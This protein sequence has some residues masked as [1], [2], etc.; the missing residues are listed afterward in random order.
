M[1]ALE[2]EHADLLSGFPRQEV[3][4]WGERFVVPFFSWAT[5][6]FTPLTL[7]YRVKLPA[8]SCAVGQMLLIRRTTYQEI[9]GHAAVRAAI[10]EDLAL[11]RRVKASGHRWRMVRAV[12]LI[13]C[14][15]YRSGR[16]AVAGSQ[17]PLRRVRLPDAT[18]SFLLWLAVRRWPRCD[19]DSVPWA[20]R[21]RATARHW[22]ASGWLGPGGVHYRELSLPVGL[23]GSTP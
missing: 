20:R 23:P 16:E 11:T 19:P 5:F 18:Y 4:T 3:L 6:C 7:A 12:G 13:S 14:R 8:L 1:S 22:Q 17:E 15:M 9:G 21:G 10:A 2:G